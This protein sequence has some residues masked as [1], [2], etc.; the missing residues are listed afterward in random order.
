MPFFNLLAR[1]SSV[2]NR[3]LLTLQ[4]KRVQH[5]LHLAAAAVAPAPNFLTALLK[6]AK[7]Q[8]EERNGF[9]REIKCQPYASVSAVTV[10]YWPEWFLLLL[11][12]LQEFQNLPNFAVWTGMFGN[13]KQVAFTVTILRNIIKGPV[14]PRKPRKRP[15]GYL[16]LI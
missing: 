3:A 14:I 10:R 7:K 12:Y 2:T 5:P 1:N 11:F 6:M 16:K 15:L 8:K 13:S 9:V 4:M